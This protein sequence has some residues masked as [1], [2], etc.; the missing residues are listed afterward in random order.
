MKIRLGVSLIVFIMLCMFYQPVAAQDCAK[1]TQIARQAFDLGENP[2]TFP[3]QKRLLTQA[4][5]LCPDH[6]EA[7][8]NLAWILG[9]ERAFE[10]ALPHYQAAVRAKPDYPD[11]W[12][13]LG[14]VYAELH[15]FPLSLEA[16]LHVCKGDKEARNK[17]VDLLK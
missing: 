14:D 8:N 15:Q 4:L 13:G 1:A 2:T 9:Q 6:P 7:H 10:E 12:Y 17:A 3:E 11:A 5:Q 16:Y